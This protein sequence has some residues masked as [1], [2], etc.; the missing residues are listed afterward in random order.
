MPEGFKV[1]VEKAVGFK[2]PAEIVSDPLPQRK[3]KKAQPFLLFD[4]LPVT[5]ATISCMHSLLVFL[6]ANCNGSMK[7]VH[8]QLA[9]LFSLHPSN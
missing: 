8:G 7:T 5:V 3:K 6:K 9:L 4:R 1:D 2:S